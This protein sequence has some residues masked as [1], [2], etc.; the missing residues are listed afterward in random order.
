[1][2]RY[3]L[4]GCEI[5]RVSFRKLSLK[6]ILWN[7]EVEV[8]V[9]FRAFARIAKSPDFTPKSGDFGLRESEGPSFYYMHHKDWQKVNG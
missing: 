6:P 4:Q 5:P 7:S 9:V 8:T 2:H 3:T 1:M